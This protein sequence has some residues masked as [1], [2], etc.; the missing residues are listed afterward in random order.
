M[1]RCHWRDTAHHPG[2]RTDREHWAGTTDWPGH[3]DGGA[4]ARRAWIRLR[5]GSQTCRRRLARA[6]ATRGPPL[7]P[8][9]ASRRAHQPASGHPV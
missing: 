7:D 9:A 4:A 8:A 3:V 2:H 5:V 1:R 6:A